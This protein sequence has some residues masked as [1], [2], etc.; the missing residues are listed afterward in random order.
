VIGGHKKVTAIVDRLSALG[1][2]K[3]GEQSVMSRPWLVTAQGDQVL[4]SQE[5]KTS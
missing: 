1:L 3:I 5:E 2:L 4:S